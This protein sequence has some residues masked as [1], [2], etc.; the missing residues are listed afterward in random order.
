VSDHSAGPWSVRSDRYGGEQ[1]RG[2]TV[3]GCD[4]GESFR[5]L[6]Y[7]WGVERK[8][9]AHLI[10]AAPDLLAACK[11][12]LPAIE[13]A[14][15][16]RRGLGLPDRAGGIGTTLPLIQLAIAKAEGRS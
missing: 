8:A 2:A 13:K 16:L 10:A 14:L 7:C 11:A 9:N 6:F 12:V 3:V 5:H 1:L 15:T 4:E